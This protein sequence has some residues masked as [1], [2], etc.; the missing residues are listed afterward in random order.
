MAPRT[1]SPH[2]N[3]PPVAAWTSGAAVAHTPSDTHSRLSAGRAGPGEPAARRSDTTH[4]D[5]AA[6]TSSGAAA[7]IAH[8]LGALSGSGVRLAAA[9]AADRKANGRS[10]RASPHEAADSTRSLEGPA[11]V[12]S[13]L[14]FSANTARRLRRSCHPDRPCGAGARA[15]PDAAPDSRDDRC[16]AAVGS[17]AGPPPPERPSP[18]R[19][20]AGAGSSATLVARTSVLRCWPAAVAVGF[21]PTDVL[22]RHTLSRRAPSAART[23][24]RR[25]A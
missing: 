22:P 13:R 16:P 6:V 15:C 25:R 5:P 18:R 24:H 8:M 23:R 9:A 7:K 10:S 4:A 11:A 12:I 2:W 1:L 21:E 19:R 3:C 17:P 20:P 14:P